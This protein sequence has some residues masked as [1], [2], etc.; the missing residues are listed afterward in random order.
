M[1]LLEPLS[2][3]ISSGEVWFS[4]VTKLFKSKSEKSVPDVISFSRSIKLSNLKAF[5]TLCL[6]GLCDL[7]FIL[8]VG[9]QL[10]CER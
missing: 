2:H 6:R 4:N 10:V 9:I 7:I 1:V 5:Q 8:C 3:L